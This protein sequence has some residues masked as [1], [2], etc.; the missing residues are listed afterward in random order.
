MEEKTTI[1][2]RK[3]DRAVE[4]EIEYINSQRVEGTALMK[5]VLVTEAEA[6]KVSPRVAGQHID[7][8]L[9][10]AEKIAYK[11]GNLRTYE[12]KL[13]RCLPPGHTSQA[14]WTPDKTPSLWKLAADPTAEY[15]E[16]S[17]PMGSFDVYNIGDKVTYKDRKWISTENDNVWAPDAFG[18]S[19]VKE[20]KA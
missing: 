11:D 17:Q 18:W 20:A 16:W 10:W 4:K 1:T 7:A 2:I 15:P 3:K 6:G 19:E 14:D 5:T 12:G 13:Y 9:P 8:F